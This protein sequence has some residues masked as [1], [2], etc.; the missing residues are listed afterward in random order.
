MDFDRFT[1]SMLLAQGGFAAFLQAVPDERGPIL[2]QITGTEI[3]SEISKRVHKRQREEHGKLELLQAETA[4]IV[5][6]SDEDEAALNQELSDKQKTEKNIS[7]KNDELE[8]SILWLIGMLV[9]VPVGV[10]VDVSVGVGVGSG[11]TS[12]TVMPSLEPML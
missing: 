5:I 9:A 12:L 8:K 7:S 11:I 10:G 2:E 1:R 6:L 4:G 3:Y